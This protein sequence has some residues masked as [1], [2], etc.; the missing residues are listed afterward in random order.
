MQGLCCEIKHN[1]PR[2][3]YAECENLICEKESGLKWAKLI[4]LCFIHWLIR[5]APHWMSKSTEKVQH[6]FNTLFYKFQL[7]SDPRETEWLSHW[8]ETH[9]TYLVTLTVLMTENSWYTFSLTFSVCTHL[10]PNSVTA[11]MSCQ[12]STAE[13]TSI[14]LWHINSNLILNLG[15]YST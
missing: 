14:I 13:H 4:M 1:R 2:I 15:T 10:Y 5:S 6:L 9:W 8:F 7:K 3:L 11:L 12:L